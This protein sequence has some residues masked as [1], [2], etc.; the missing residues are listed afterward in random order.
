M[1][2]LFRNFKKRIHSELWERG[3]RMN[4]VGFR[5]RVTRFLYW[6]F[7]TCCNKKDAD[8]SV[9]SFDPWVCDPQAIVS[10][11]YMHT[12]EDANWISYK[13]T[14]TARLLL[15]VHHITCNESFDCVRLYISQKRQYLRNIKNFVCKTWI[16]HRNSYSIKDGNPGYRYQ[17]PRN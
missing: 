14:V 17:Y 8:P 4:E 15:C 2:I 11:I 7:R 5:T 6:E 1:S 9:I 12:L 3:H 16:C 10:M 13:S